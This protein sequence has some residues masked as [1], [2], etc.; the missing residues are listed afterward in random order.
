MI[1]LNSIIKRSFVLLT[2]PLA[3]QAIG[4]ICGLIDKS[5]LKYTLM[6]AIVFKCI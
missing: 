1:W 5:L 4:S 3:W 2:M 6:Y